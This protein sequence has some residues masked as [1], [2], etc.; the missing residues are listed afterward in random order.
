MARYC[1]KEL[2]KFQQIPVFQH[3][4]SPIQSESHHTTSKAG[5]TSP[6][7]LYSINIKEAVTKIASKN[8]RRL[9]KCNPAR[10]GIGKMVKS[11]EIPFKRL[12][13]H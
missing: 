5:E 8:G 6:A 9:A 13:S 1:G 12:S 2:N 3:V 11:V 10:D 4:G 7:S